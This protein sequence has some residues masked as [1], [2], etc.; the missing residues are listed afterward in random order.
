MR[1]LF[2]NM[3]QLFRAHADLKMLLLM[4]GL[5]VLPAL[6]SASD[7]YV[8][9]NAVGSNSGADCADAHAI[10]W[11][12]SAANWGSAAGQ[13][14]PG[15]TLHLC[16]TIAVPGGSAG[17]VVQGSGTSASPVTIKFEANAVLQSAYFSGSNFDG[18]CTSNCGGGIQVDGVNYII[19]DGGTNGI[20]QNTSNGTNLANHQ[21][22]SDGI[23]IAGNNVIVRNLTI[24][25]IYANAG[26]SSSASDANGLHTADIRVDG[27][28]TN[29]MICNNTLNNARAGIT[30][31]TSGGSAGGSGTCQSNAFTTGVNYYNNTLTD[32]AWQMGINGG[33]TVNVYNNDIGT[34]ANWQYPSSSYH[35]DG[36]IV[37]GDSSPIT[38]YIYGNYFHGDLGLG[39]PTAEI[40]CT[41]GGTGSGSICNIFNN[42]IV[43][44][45]TSATNA[46][47]I[48]VGAS[49]S[50]S[51]IGPIYISNNTI[52]GFSMSIFPYGAV[53]GGLVIEN[54]IGVQNGNGYFVVE[55]NNTFASVLTAC[56]H[57]NW[58][59][60]RGLPFSDPSGYY[61]FSTWQ[62]AGYDGNGSSGNPNLDGTY[63]LQSG[64]SAIGLA[65]NPTALSGLASMISALDFAPLDDGE[66]SIVGVNGTSDGIVRTG[67]K[68]DGG[69]YPSSSATAAGPPAPHGLAAVVVN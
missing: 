59:G 3:A 36:L 41:Y 33:G 2:R 27:G 62:S 68:W 9:Q 8:A 24:Q 65:I 49:I 22:F 32:H 19:V 31:D 61:N 52:V 6:A 51:P 34:N 43:G 47:G 7:I 16:G 26:S 5:L 10:A 63:H 18:W 39:S 1:S 21:D 69:A 20:I 58:Y 40:Y 30:S 53:N 66:P 23:H 50:S 29:V 4:A 14:G 55:N 11:A 37:F 57:N 42:V 13:I 25:N 54:N 64:S 44:T 67:S 38:A 17:L 45:G 35:T 15:T 60:G 46:V 56:D 12:N 48:W 28:S